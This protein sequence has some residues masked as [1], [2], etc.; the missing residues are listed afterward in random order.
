MTMLLACPSSSIYMMYHCISAAQGIGMERWKTYLLNIEHCHP[1]EYAVICCKVA[2]DVPARMFGTAELRELSRKMIH[3]MQSAPGVGLAAPQI[4][5]G[6][7]VDIY[8][9]L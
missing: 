4:A 8:T 9:P 3:I 2:E 6:L 7:K 1:R 5:V